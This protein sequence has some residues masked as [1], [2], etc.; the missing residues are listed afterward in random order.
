M[1]EFAEQS[2]PGASSRPLPP[3]D[4]HVP[5]HLETATFANG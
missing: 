4:L 1:S 5:Q 3:I 2:E